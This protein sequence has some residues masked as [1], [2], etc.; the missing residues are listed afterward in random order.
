VTQSIARSFFFIV[1]FFFLYH[2]ILTVVAQVPTLLLSIP[3]PLDLSFSFLFFFSFLFARARRCCRRSC[4]RRCKPL[5]AA[6]LRAARKRRRRKR[7]RSAPSGRSAAGPATTAGTWRPAWLP[8]LH[9]VGFRAHGAAPHPTRRSPRA[10]SS[11]GHRCREFR[12]VPGS[13]RARRQAAAK[14]PPLPTGTSC[15][16]A[17]SADGSAAA[18]LWGQEKP[19]ARAASVCRPGL[20]WRPTAFRYP[21]LE[22]QVVVGGVFVERIG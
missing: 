9:A 2:L 3:P 12:C 11:G 15:C 8:L 13:G 17:P 14:R 20:R 4:S 19:R 6:Q 7:R 10:W 21:V 1:V 16:W 18:G 5:P 22:A